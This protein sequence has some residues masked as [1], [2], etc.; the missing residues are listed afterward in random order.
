MAW[1]KTRIRIETARDVIPM[2]DSDGKSV[3]HI[4]P[5]LIERRCG[6]WLAVSNST[7]PLKIGVTADTEEQAREA[8]GQAV[9]EWEAILRTGL[10]EMPLDGHER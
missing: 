5:R 7:A 1:K 3:N 2:E 4:A 8:F 10:I 6:G 9:R